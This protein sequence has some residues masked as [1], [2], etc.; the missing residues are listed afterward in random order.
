[1]CS[2]TALAP[3]D[4]PPTTAPRAYAARIA[5]PKRVPAMTAAR[6]SWLPPVMKTPSTSSSAAA[7]SGSSASSRVCGRSGVV[8]GSAQRPEHLVVALE[9]LRAQRRRGR[10]DGDPRAV[11]AGQPDELAQ[12]DALAD[13]VLG[14][15]DD[16]QSS[17][18]D[19]HDG[20]SR[21]GCERTT[22]RALGSAHGRAGA[23]I[24]CLEHDAFVSDST[25]VPTGAAGPRRLVLV[26][27]AKAVSDSGG[28]DR[29]R[30]LTDSGRNDA[31][32]VGELAGRTAE[33]GRRRLVV[34]RRA[35][36]AD[37]RGHRRAAARSPVRVDLR[38]DL[39]DAGPDD[40]LELVREA[41]DSVRRA[42]G[43]RP[44]PHDR[45]GSGLAQR[46]RP[47]LPRRCGRDRGVR[48]PWADLD[49]G[50]ARLVA[51]TVP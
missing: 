50:D 2:L 33:L 48:G 4:V 17:G 21:H 20:S 35:S 51:F 24:A 40:L 49:P 3:A 37:L 22:P 12:H 30:E 1:M 10:H 11:A 47:R 34:V 8:G 38:D 23:D 5:S 29:A 44:Q 26:R 7:S 14:A 31:A 9:D 28:S 36:P 39:Y 13:A 45:A 19:G 41:D 25:D 15:T 16:A 6:M 43:R 32:R 42:H 27:H 18:S 46:G